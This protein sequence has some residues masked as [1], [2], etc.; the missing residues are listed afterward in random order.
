M[1]VESRIYAAIKCSQQWMQPAPLEL[2]SVQKSNTL[3]CKLWK[4]KD[5]Q[6]MKTAD[7][8]LEIGHYLPQDLQTDSYA[9]S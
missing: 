5:S 2:V 7:E 6:W 1:L 4:H 8:T 3:H 9:D